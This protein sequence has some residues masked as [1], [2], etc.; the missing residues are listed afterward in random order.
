MATEPKKTV[1]KETAKEGGFSGKVK[2]ISKHPIQLS[3]KTI[4]PGQVGEC[5]AAELSTFHLYIQRV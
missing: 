3:G 5:T 2:N 4:E 1:A